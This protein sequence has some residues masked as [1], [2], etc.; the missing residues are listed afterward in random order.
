MASLQEKQPSA[1]AVVDGQESAPAERPAL[2]GCEQRLGRSWRRWADIVDAVAHKRQVRRCGGPN[3]YADLHR[4]LLGCCRSLAE[5]N[6]SRREFFL[7][8]EGVARPWTSLRTLAQTDGDTLL[9]LSQQCRDV[10][11]RLNGRRL[12]LRP[13]WVL[14]VALVS[15]TAAVV[16][17]FPTQAVAGLQSALDEAYRLWRWLLLTYRQSSDVER[18]IFVGFIVAVVSMVIA[19]RAR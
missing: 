15:T 17:L 5:G 8:L 19:W 18:L 9:A 10:D 11:R 3:D 2:A 6:G 13:G 16:A 7:L 14:G 1:V 4:D 12:R